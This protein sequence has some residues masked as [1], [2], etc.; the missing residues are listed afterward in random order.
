MTTAHHR[1]YLVPRPGHRGGGAAR[2]AGRSRPS[3]AGRA[4]PTWQGSRPSAGTGTTTPRSASSPGGRSTSSST[5]AASCP[6]WSASR[7]GC[8][9]SP[10]RTTSSSRASRPRRPGRGPTPRRTSRASRAP[11]TPG[12]T[13]ATTA[14]SRPAAS[15]QSSRCSA[16]SATIA[17]AGLIIG[18]HE[19]V[20]RLPAWL[21]RMARG[22]EVLA[23]GTPDLPMQL[24][25][26]RDLA[27]FML[28]CGE[29]GTPGTFN[30]T[31]PTGNATYGSML[32]DCRT[33]YR[34]GRHPHLGRRRVP[35]RARGR[36]VDRAAAVD[37]ARRPRR[38][39][40]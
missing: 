28:G 4:T 27:A 25:D 29:A 31:A 1:R 36:A 22:G 34:F 8:W 26:A 19:N 17:R 5:P 24:V 30:A 6:A 7:R 18:P 16:I 37:A 35:A 33:R 10:A 13:T 40:R 38:R 3:T 14:S 21:D 2:A 15:A 39:Q 9:R 32:D 20:G 11:R 12:P 23:P